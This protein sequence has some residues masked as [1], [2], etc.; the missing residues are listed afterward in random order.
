MKPMFALARHRH[1]IAIAAGLFAAVGVGAAVGAQIGGGI[2]L[3][4]TGRP[5]TSLARTEAA[6][7][8][9]L[10]Y[11]GRLTSASGQPVT[12]TV[13]VRFEL[14]NVSNSVVYSTSN[15]SVTPDTSG[16]FTTQI[17]DLTDNSLNRAGALQEAVAVRVLIN[18]NP[19]SPTQSINTLVG[20]SGDG[21]GVVGRSA[22][23]LGVAGYS[24]GTTGAGV[25]GEAVGT[26]GWGVWGNSVSS[27]GVRGEGLGA[28][29]G[30]WGTS[31]GGPGV[32]ADS[33]N[34]I[35]L[36]ARTNVITGGFAIDAQGHIRQPREQ[37]GT[38][39]ALY[40]T[41][42]GGCF[43]AYGTGSTVANGG[44]GFA[45][46]I[47]TPGEHKINFGF[48]VDDRFI[49]VTPSLANTSAVIAQIARFEDGGNSVVIK[50]Y[51][52]GSGIPA[53]STT[54]V[55]VAVH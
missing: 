53:P 18:G 49:Q 54:P 28:E 8:N 48:K 35:G 40:N 23:G 36:L 1:W 25:K 50:T 52:L 44:C 26:S 43:N 10:S 42:T 12:T 32:L 38:V 16:L 24:V 15:K 34:G 29:A 14:L 55:H 13:T 41:T 47:P 20:A 33:I 39:K 19:L 22:N 27:V 3:N 17:G 4:D 37:A 11:Q 7:V 30:V 51:T 45:Y 6:V 9:A 21:T 2:K 31:L 46:T 5:D